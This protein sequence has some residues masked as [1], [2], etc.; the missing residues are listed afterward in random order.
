KDALAG[1]AFAMMMAANQTEGLT[2]VFTSIRPQS[3]QIVIDVDRIKA[4]SMGVRLADIFDTLQTSLGSAYVNDFNRFGR[5]YQVYAQAEAK[6]R[7]HASDITRLKVRNEQGGMVPLGSL[8]QVRETTGLDLASTYNLA[9]SA[10]LMGGTLPGV[11]SG[12]AIAKIEKLAE[13]VLPAGFTI[14][15]TELTLQEILAGNS[16]VYIFPL[17]VLFVFLALAA[18]YESWSLP[19]AIILIVP[20][21]I[22]AAL[23][24]VMLRGMD[25]NIFTQIGLVVLVGLASKN[26]ILIVE[27][28]KQLEDQGRST[29]DA[30]VEACRLRLR[31]ILMT[32]FAFILG[33][34]PLAF[35]SGAGSEMRRALGT[36]VFSGMIGVTFFGL[37][38]TPVFYFVVRKLTGRRK[39]AAEHEAAEAE[40]EPAH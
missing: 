38:L 15:W 28:A 29:F 22:L 34:V 16:A 3:P 26:A 9:A 20:L 33:V 32:S 2:G 11:S 30:A 31:P 7:V 40:P 4:K 6:Y 25:N 5:V 18:Q 8:V 12:Q 27:F 21:V 39:K 36:A 10:D 1:A 13:Q 14:D 24:G 37:F 19:L 23:V 17:C 35:A